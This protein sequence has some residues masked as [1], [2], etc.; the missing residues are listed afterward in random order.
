MSLFA[1]GDLHLSLGGEKPMDVFGGRWQDYTEKIVKGFGAVVGEKDTT[2]LCG[3]LTWG[4]DMDA[5][6]EDFKFIHRLPGRKIILKGNHDYWWSTASKAKKF[7]AE[8]QIDSIDILHN[9]FFEYEDI[10]ICGTRGWFYEEERGDGHDK[11]ILARECL[12]L[13]ASLKAAGE[14]EKY[15]FLHYPPKYQGYECSEILKLLSDYSVKMCCYGHIHSKGCASA[16][17]GELNGTV[18]RLVSADYLDFVPAKIC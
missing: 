3:D 1:I 6:L 17:N 12:R 4:M 15:V 9:N 10:A 5:A 16:F 7:F 8:N 14:R 11:K 2:V 13:E 18:F